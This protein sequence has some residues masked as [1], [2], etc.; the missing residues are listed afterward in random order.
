[1][2]V[3]NGASGWST[4][5]SDQVEITCSLRASRVVVALIAAAGETASDDDCNIGDMPQVTQ[6]GARQ[7]LCGSVRPRR[8]VI[9]DVGEYRHHYRTR[10]GSL[11]CDSLMVDASVQTRF[12][13]DIIV[14]VRDN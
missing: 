8:C 3:E 2:G 10:R 9:T 4:V 1:M 14:S 12:T 13:S 7:R 5:Y 6:R 11:G